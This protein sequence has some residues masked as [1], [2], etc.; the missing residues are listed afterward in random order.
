MKIN[1]T[2]TTHRPLRRC[3]SAIISLIAVNIFTAT[4]AFAQYAGGPSTGTADTTIGSDIFMGG[5]QGG[6]SS[7]TS[8][9][10]ANLSHGDATHVAFIVSPSSTKHINKFDR[11]PIVALLDAN[12]N[13][14][15]SDNAT[16]VTIAILNNPGAATLEGTTIVTVV[17]GLA[18]F[19]DLQISHIRS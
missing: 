5:A 8:G 14:V 6:S 1:K 9:S 11:Q 16:Q 15:T 18:K 10:A 3:V 13:I 17:N 12:N 19:Q 4:F 2:T 7:A